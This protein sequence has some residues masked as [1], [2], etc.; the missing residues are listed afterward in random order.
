MVEEL[1]DVCHLLLHE[2]ALRRDDP[3]HAELYARLMTDPLLYREVADRLAAVG[4]ELVQVFGHLG[5]RPLAEAAEAAGGRNRMGLD[6]RHVRVLVYLWV[7]LVYRE[8][9]E[10]RRGHQ[11]PAPGTE[12]QS[13]LLDDDDDGPAAHM[14][15]RKLESDFGHMVAPRQIKATLTTLQRLRFV[16]VARAQ[17]RIEA[18]ASLHTL[19][20]RN[21]MEDFVIDLTRRL[22]ADSPEQ[23]VI[24][25]AVG[26]PGSETPAADRERVS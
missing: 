23:A 26:E 21:R 11:P 7:H 19:I 12:Q 18:D 4:Y 2:G 13:L 22:G 25:A 9:L 20:D 6:A 16:R 3:E 15:L 5:V 1:R 10:L 24:E 14:S 17:D 8:W